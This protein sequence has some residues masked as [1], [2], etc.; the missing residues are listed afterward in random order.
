[1]K[2]VEKS[3]LKT[4]SEVEDLRQQ[5]SDL[6]LELEKAQLKIQYYEEQLR[7]SRQKRFGKSSEKIDSDQL[8][9]FNEAEMEREMISPEPKAEEALPPKR[10]PKGRKAEITAKFEEEI[11]ECPLSEE[12]KVCPKCGEPLH[13]VK[14]V[15]TKELKIIPAKVVVT[16]Y[17]REVYACRNCDQNG[18]TGTIVTAAMPKRPLENSLASPSLLAYIM[19]RKYTQALPLYRQEAEF[20]AQGIKLSRQTMANWCISVS[21]RW[22]RPLYE[23]MHERLK[24][25]AVLHADETPVEV[26]KMPGT[27]EPKK[28]YMWL[29]RTAKD[30]V[31]II[32]YE[33]G[34]G[35]SGSIP[36]EF[37]KGFLGYLTV[38]GY[39]GYDQLTQDG[40]V[41]AG[42]WAHARRAYT[43]ALKS[44]SEEDRERAASL[45]KGLAYCDELF[46]IERDIADL[47]IQERFKARVERSQKVV[48]E[49]FAWAKETYLSTYPKTPLGKALGYS[50]NQE[51]KLRTFLKD[52][53]VE[54]S[55]NAAER[56]IKPFV[57]GRKNWLFANT[58]N[59]ANASA[60]IYSIIESAKANGLDPF[61]YLTYLLNKLPNLDKGTPKELDRLVPWS[62]DLPVE[63]RN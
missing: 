28:C 59:G 58:P 29:Y 60:I 54:L 13:Y 39:I 10:R 32:L 20:K 18:T 62:A 52:G 19:T 16:V 23:R 49:Y 8:Q 44:L 5:V 50:L 26:L 15:E 46:S 11:V 31:P 33:Y 1:M 63:L 35:R 61:R 17:R 22:L 36:R 3:S 4:N 51:E 9:F 55:N 40:I 25:S 7:L 14:T 43:D 12:E 2:T 53:R 24:E 37:L 21:H 48:D 27:E 45:G 57:I 47:S 34:Q 6:K 38:D 41:L 30:N 42:C 56:A